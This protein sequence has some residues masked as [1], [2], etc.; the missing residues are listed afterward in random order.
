MNTQ[1]FRDHQVLKVKMRVT[2]GQCTYNQVLGL[3]NPHTVVSLHS[4]G[5]LLIFA[6]L[7]LRRGAPC[8]RFSSK[9]RSAFIVLAIGESDVLAYNQPEANRRL[10]HR[11][12][13]PLAFHARPRD[14]LPGSRSEWKD[15]EDKCLSTLTNKQGRLLI[16]NYPHCPRTQ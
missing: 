13:N 10:V 8:I 6:D 1:S 12:T 16:E 14:C 11:H 4:I 3:P 15:T 5:K 9:A 7:A 2:Q